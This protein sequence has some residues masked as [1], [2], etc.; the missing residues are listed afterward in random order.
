MMQ[1]DTE[2]KIRARAHQIWERSGCLDGCAEE[3][4]RI[5]EQEVL[6]AIT[7]ERIG[8][9]RALAAAA[10]AASRRAAPRAPRAPA[11]RKAKSAA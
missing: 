4:W 8:E 7:S 1:L 9:M 3:H 10:N 5:A 11:A 6:T 2:Q